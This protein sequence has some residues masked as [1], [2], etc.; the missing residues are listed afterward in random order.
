[1]E[2]CLQS[3]LAGPSPQFEDEIRDSQLR[4]MFVCCHPGLPA[5]AQVALTLKTLCGFG[6]KE[7]AAAFLAT[8][9]R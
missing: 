8:A 3:A 9:T 1:M 2:D 7:I 5:E 4:M 6:E